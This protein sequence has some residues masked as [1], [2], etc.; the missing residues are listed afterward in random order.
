MASAKAATLA[1]GD[2][3][4]HP[5]SRKRVYLRHEESLSNRKSVNDFDDLGASRNVT[6]EECLSDSHE[7][8]FD[9]V[10]V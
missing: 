9:A 4:V 8:G 2:G 10:S 6:G 1:F 5:I 7:R 3:L